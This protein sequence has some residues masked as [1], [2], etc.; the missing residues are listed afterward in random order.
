MHS[1]FLNNW[2]V[3]AV[4]VFLKA[5]PPVLHCWYMFL[6]GSNVIILMY[7]PVHY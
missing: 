6:P 1:V 4:M 7:L 5:M 2:K 3:L